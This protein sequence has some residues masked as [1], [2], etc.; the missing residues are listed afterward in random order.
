MTGRPEPVDMVAVALFF[1]GGA[2]LAL[3]FAVIYVGINLINM[4]GATWRFI[5]M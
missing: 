2:V 4:M 5:W 3:A 1:I